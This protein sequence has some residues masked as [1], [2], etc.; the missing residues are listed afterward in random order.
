MS[1]SAYKSIEAKIKTF[2]KRQQ[3]LTRATSELD[4]QIDSVKRD[5]RKPNVSGS[6]GKAADLL[7]RQAQ[8]TA[9]RQALETKKTELDRQSRDLQKTIDTHKFWAEKAKYGDEATQQ[10][11]LCRLS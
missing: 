11:A 7:K 8:A 10:E 9:K 1:N 5:Q 2:E 3:E 6:L 4:K